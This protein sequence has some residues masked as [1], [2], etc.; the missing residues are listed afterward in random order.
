MD[1]WQFAPSFFAAAFVLLVPGAIVGRALGARGWFLAGA[2]GPVS[3]SI[4]A[5][6]AIGCGFLRVPWSL[7][8]VLLVTFLAAVVALGFGL[9]ARRKRS[10]VQ[11]QHAK[12]LP[13]VGLPGAVALFSVALPAGLILW[14]F[15]QIVGESG[16]I[17][18]TFDNIFHLNALRYIEETGRA[19]SLQV[20]GFTS[21]SG[22]AGFYP[23]AWHDVV[24]LVS[25]LSGAGI[26][27]A[28]NATNTAIAAILWP[29]SSLFLVVCLFGKRSAVLLPAAALISGFASFP[30][31]MVDFG[32]LYP[33]F[34][35]ISILPA[36]IALVVLV[37][38][39]DHG[40]GRGRGLGMMLLLLLLP[41]LALA[42]PSTLLA[43]LPWTLPVVIAA[44]YRRVFVQREH[45]GI[46]RWWPV[47]AL[48][49]YTGLV[50]FLWKKLRPEESASLWEPVESLSQA[51]GQAITSAPM[52]GPVPWAIFLLTVIGIFALIRN[53]ELRWFLAVF[54]VSC[55]AFVIVAGASFGPFRTFVG[56]VWYNDPYRPAALL[57]VA[58][59]PVAVYGAM[60]LWDGVTARMRSSVGRG[61]L[62]KDSTHSSRAL[63]TV[64]AVCA[65]LLLSG[66]A[67][68]GA[69]NTAVNSAAHNYKMSS[70]SA[71]LSVDE[72]ILL[73]RIPQ[74]VPA[75]DTIVANPWTGAS[76]VYALADRRSLTAHVFG[77][78]DE[79]TETVLQELDELSTNPEVCEAVHK[80]R[81]YYVLDF[82]TA[83]VHNTSH[84]FAG[85]D[86]IE[87]SPGFTL[88]DS[89]GDAKL[90]KVTGCE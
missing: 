80:L 89:Q 26:P 72:K 44:T 32:V 68:R 65:T 15:G 27:Q 90:Y 19:S 77:T 46:R 31:L 64:A 4:V 84:P 13:V 56:G 87:E 3:I 38:G 33:N 39:L 29:L 12:G 70:T 11:G 51:M 2:A 81:S 10:E 25:Q 5:L 30:Y 47:V 16:N 14:R 86:R 49:A 52:S 54:T 57:P 62:G 28:V 67:Q 82:G 88:V 22:Q 53:S 43:L 69:V 35:S 79:T 66:A 9:L 83:E 75:E 48:V 8:A 59:L 45:R 61:L 50:A 37:F 58:A 71:L 76:L 73:E 40:R 18:Q 60:T 7:L 17:S 78:Y 21:S 24:S 23:A 74:L 1:Y 42:H 41:G 34:L 20:A 63:I 85:T 6:T 36:A 55:F